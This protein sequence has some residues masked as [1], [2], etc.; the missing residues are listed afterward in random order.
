MKISFPKTIGLL[1]QLKAPPLG[2]LKNLPMPKEPRSRSLVRAS[3][4][5]AH[6]KGAPV[7]MASE[8]FGFGTIHAAEAL[9]EIRVRL[10]AHVIE[11]VFLTEAVLVRAL[12]KLRAVR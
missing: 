2:K 6:A 10:D 11:P 1:A 8:I 5:R 3:D 4:L 12:Q 9:I 7:G